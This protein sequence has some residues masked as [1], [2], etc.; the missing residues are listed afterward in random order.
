MFGIAFHFS[1]A[2]FVGFNKD[3]VCN[4]LHRKC[5]GVEK[6]F[7][8]ESLFRR[9]HIRHDVFG[10]LLDTGGKPCESKR[11]PHDFEE[12]ATT[13]VVDPFGCLTGKF[14]VEKF[15]EAVNRGQFVETAPVLA[16]GFNIQRLRR[17]THR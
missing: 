5:G 4:T 2:E 6:R 7:A 8:G 11:R 9:I 13:L 17:I 16:D 14:A 15:F 12:V 3:G 1:G 10:G